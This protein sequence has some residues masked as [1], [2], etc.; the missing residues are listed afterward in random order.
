MASEKTIYPSDIS[1][2]QFAQILPLLESA[3]KRTSPRDL[4]LY[5]VNGTNL[6]V[7]IGESFVREALLGIMRS[8]AKN[9]IPNRLLRETFWLS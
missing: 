7:I 9:K 6:R 3:K 8:C 1:R 5:E 2:E 4:D